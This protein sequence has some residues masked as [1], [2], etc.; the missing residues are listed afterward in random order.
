MQK[1]KQTKCDPKVKCYCYFSGVN[2]MKK[3]NASMI[4][5]Y[6]QNK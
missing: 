2:F 1:V 6:F 5:L 4:I 3:Q